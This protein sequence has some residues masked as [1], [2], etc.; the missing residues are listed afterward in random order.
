MQLKDIKEDEIVYERIPFME[1]Y[2]QS[3]NCGFSIFRKDI[4]SVSYNKIS[5]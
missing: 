4:T 3:W 1:K 5:I 2:Y